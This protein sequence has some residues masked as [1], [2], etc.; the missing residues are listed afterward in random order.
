MNASDIE[1]RTSEDWKPK[2]FVIGAVVGALV[3]VGAAYLL[4]QQAES[5][6]NK[7]DISGSEGV[8][9]GIAVLGLLRQVASLG[10]KG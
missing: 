1:T 8:K 2:L 5:E 4:A 10:E 7:P 6:G 3:G 9:L